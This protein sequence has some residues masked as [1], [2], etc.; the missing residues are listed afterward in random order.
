MIRTRPIIIKL[1]IVAGLELL[2][3]GTEHC[4]LTKGAKVVYIFL[5]VT[6]A[7]II[8]MLISAGFEP[9]TPK[10]EHCALTK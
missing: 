6:R 2:T 7:I 5:I 8:K 1:L 10:K 4:A 3:P 9:I